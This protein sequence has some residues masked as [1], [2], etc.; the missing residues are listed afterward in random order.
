MRKLSKSKKGVITQ[1]MIFIILSIIII[2]IFG[3]V[4]PWGTLM[5]TSA[6]VA[7]EGLINQS[8]ETANSLNDAEVKAEIIGILEESTEMT[9][10]NIQVTSGM[11]KYAWLFFIIILALAIFLYT[12]RSVE[13][14][15]GGFV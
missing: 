3:I 11:Y 9:V 8:M 2:F 12:R 1:V 6:Y 10:T 7:G 15:Q 14:G 5:S 13:L 4:A